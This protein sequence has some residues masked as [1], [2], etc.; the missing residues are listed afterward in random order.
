MS[1]F[2]QDHKNAMDYNSLLFIVGTCVLLPVIIPIAAIVAVLSLPFL[3]CAS[4]LCLS[5]MHH[6]NVHREEYGSRY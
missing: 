6:D 4:L 2:F 3:A 5:E 1:K